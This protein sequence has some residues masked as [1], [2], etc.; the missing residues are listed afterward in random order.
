MAGAAVGVNVARDVLFPADDVV[1]PRLFIARQRRIGSGQMR[2]TH[3]LA[4]SNGGAGEH[5]Q[6]CQPERQRMPA[7][8]WPQQDELAVAVDDVAH[9]LA[10]AAPG[11]YLLAHDKAEIAGKRRIR[12]VDRLVLADQAAQ[13][14]GQRAG[15]RLLRRIGKPLIGLDGASGGGEAD[16]E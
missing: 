14:R 9:N 8:P 7:K 10:V 2:R 15:P 12:I 5:Q 16:G 6:R 11:L 1:Q 13:F 4:D 3:A